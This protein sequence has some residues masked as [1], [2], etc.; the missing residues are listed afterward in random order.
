MQQIADWLES[1][2]MSEYVRRRGSEPFCDLQ[3]STV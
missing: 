3:Q 2:G 1:L